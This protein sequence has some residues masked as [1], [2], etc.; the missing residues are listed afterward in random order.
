M[1][2]VKK[3]FSIKSWIKTFE[4]EENICKFRWGKGC[5]L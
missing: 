2:T 5:Y 3:N 4:Y 1:E